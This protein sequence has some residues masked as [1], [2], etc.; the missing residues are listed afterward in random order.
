MDGMRFV[1]FFG[2]SGAGKKT[3][4]RA[5]IANADH[6][7]R[8]QFELV[9]P[10]VAIEAAFNTED[11]PRAPIWNEIESVWAAPIGTVLIKGQ[12]VDI[13]NQS[14]VS[15]PGQ[16]RDARPESSHEILA[17]WAQGNVLHDRCVERDYANHGSADAHSNELQTQV[18]RLPELGLKVTWLRTHNGEWLLETPP[19]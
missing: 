15:L 13:C 2:P 5:V 14:E 6:P 17:L 9:E 4:I 18:D 11:R 7:L 16:L 10:V 12:W 1:W 3:T 8:D 19:R